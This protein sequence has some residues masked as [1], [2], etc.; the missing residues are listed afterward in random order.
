[1]G[2]LEVI[3]HVALAAIQADTLKHHLD[4]V[5]GHHV[6]VDILAVD[7]G[8]VLAPVVF[9]HTRV[10]D[11]LP[12]A[13]LDVGLV[14]ILDVRV[15]VQL[16]CAI[17][18]VLS[19]ENQSAMIGPTALVVLGLRNRGQVLHSVGLGAGCRIHPRIMAV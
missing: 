14:L 5:E 7:D 18:A 6:V 12:C 19:M 4:L 3:R 11:V 8:E 9:Q 1:M 17:L 10:E 13:L 15:E 16:R 2:A